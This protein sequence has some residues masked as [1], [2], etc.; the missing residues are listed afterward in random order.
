[1]AVH[2]PAPVD[3]GKYIE[4]R[5]FGER[6]HLRGRRVPVAMVVQRMRANNWTIAETAYDF[7]LS[8][9]EVTAA[10]LYYEEHKDLIDGQEIEAAQEYE[11]MKRQHDSLKPLIAYNTSHKAEEHPV[12]SLT[13]II[14]AVDQLNADDKAKLRAYMDEQPTAEQPAAFRRVAGLHEH[15]GHARVSEAFDAPLTNE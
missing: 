2:T 14:Q 7:T 11:E 1:M 13:D 5:L 4:I 9:A 15:L 6:P 8:E 10:I 3:L 12:V